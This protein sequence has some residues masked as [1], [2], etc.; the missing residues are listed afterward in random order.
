MVWRRTFD[1]T[2]DQVGEGLFAGTGRA[3][4][5]AQI[6]SELCNNTILHTRSGE[7]GG[8]FGVEV[9]L[10]DLAYLAVTDQ[11]GKGRPVLQP[12]PF[13]P[14]D[15]AEGGYGIMVVADLA[16]TIGVHGSPEL[17]HTT[18]A[19]LDLTRKTDPATQD[20]VVM[21]IA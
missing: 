5:A 21:L 18:W 17:G 10:G 3:G 12:K 20:G 16:L 8:W 15:P 4:D 11:G 9:A 13:D 7:E 19:D 14:D 2:R 6:I 1:G